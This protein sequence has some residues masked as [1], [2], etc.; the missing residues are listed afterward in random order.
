MNLPLISISRLEAALYEWHLLYGSEVVD[1]EAGDSSITGCLASAVDCIP[2]D[3]KLV[4]IRY[5]GIHMGTFHVKSLRE[6]PGDVAE[7][8]SEL[9]AAYVD[10]IS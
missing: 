6:M 7:R 1:A 3:G 5:R 10:T 4:E 2:E 9:Y 8:V